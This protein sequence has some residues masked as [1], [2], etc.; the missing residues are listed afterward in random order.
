MPFIDVK[1]SQK[2]TEEQ[3]DEIKSALGGAVSLLHKP[4]SYLMVGIADG[5]SLYFAGKK[6]EGAYVGVSLFGEVKSGDSEKMTAK[7]CDILQNCAKISPDKVYV[8]YRGV[9][10]WGWNGGNF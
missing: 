4:E 8:T 6:I 9:R 2:L 1:I 7:I 10:D 3:K 5:Y